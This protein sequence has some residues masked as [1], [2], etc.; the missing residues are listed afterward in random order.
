MKASAAILTVLGFFVLIFGLGWLVQGNDFFMYQYFAPKY[1]AVR[2]DTFE[3]TKSYQQGMIQDLRRMQEEYIT[4]DKE[5]QG[6]LKSLILHAAADF[7]D[8]N[9]PADLR[10]FLQ[11][12]RSEL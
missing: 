11:K 2:R 7:P 9:L 4:T 12:L 3:Q 8:E 1:E 5:H 6:A 10:E